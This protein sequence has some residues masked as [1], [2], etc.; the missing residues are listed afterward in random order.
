[1][2]LFLVTFCRNVKRLCVYV[3]NDALTVM[4]PKLLSSMRFSKDW[5][6]AL[7]GVLTSRQVSSSGALPT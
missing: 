2:Q 6:R 4:R 1:M 7:F 5:D 3:M